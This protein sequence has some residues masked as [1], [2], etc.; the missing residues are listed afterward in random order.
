MGKIKLPVNE[1]Q[2]ITVIM[3]LYKDV[4]ARNIVSALAINCLEE[5][6]DQDFAHTKDMRTKMS[7]FIEAHDYKGV[8]LRRARNK[9]AL[10]QQELGEKFGTSKVKVRRMETNKIPLSQVAI[11]LILEHCEGK[12]FKRKKVQKTL[13]MTNSTYLA[14]NAKIAPERIPPKTKVSCQYKAPK[15]KQFTKEEAFPH[16]YEKENDND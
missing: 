6:T 3:R 8:D 9:L 13:G 10:N 16:L 12:K 7:R 11:N 15:L 4:E 14:K 1:E 5:Y 2:D